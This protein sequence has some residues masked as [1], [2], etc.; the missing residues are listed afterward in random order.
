M[1]I[2]EAN[3]SRRIPLRS[4][5]NLVNS[6]RRSATPRTSSAVVA[7]QA[8]VGTRAA[9]GHGVSRSVY[10]GERAKAPQATVGGPELPQK[11]KRAA[12]ALQNNTPSAKRAK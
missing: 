5:D 11:P 6:P 1:L 8:S 9:G 3:R 4:A 7:A 10:W 2:P 12:T